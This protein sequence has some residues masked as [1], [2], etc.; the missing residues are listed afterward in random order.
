[1][2]PITQACERCD[3]KFEDYSY[4]KKKQNNS[5]ELP[6]EKRDEDQQLKKLAPA[7]QD[8]KNEDH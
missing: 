8:K 3:A 4:R 5:T 7:P 6:A 1:M 2:G